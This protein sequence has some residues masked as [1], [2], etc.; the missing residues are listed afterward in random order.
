MCR[1]A[2]GQQNQVKSC[3]AGKGNK[4]PSPEETKTDVEVQALPPCCAG[5]AAAAED[6]LAE[7]GAVE[8]TAAASAV[9]AEHAPKK[10]N[11]AKLAV[12]PTQHT[13]QTGFSTG[14]G[15]QLIGVGVIS[16]AVLGAAVYF[17]KRFIRAQMP[18]MKKVGFFDQPS[19]PP[20]CFS[21]VL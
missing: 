7:A 19:L 21:Y 5:K 8:T 16:A 4:D 10:V 17:G 12:Q 20:P 18:E 13:Q 15:L 1:A 11:M 9:M 2:E 6:V 14:P 3:C